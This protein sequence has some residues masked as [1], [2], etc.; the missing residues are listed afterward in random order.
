[1]TSIK[2]V[3]CRG[4]AL[5]GRREKT[6]GF[7]IIPLLLILAMLTAAAVLYTHVVLYELEAAGEFI[8]RSR[9]EAITQSFVQTALAEEGQT[10]IKDGSWRLGNLMP[11][12]VTADINVSVKRMKALGMR[13][14]FVSTT[15]T[16]GREFHLR[17]CRITLPKMLTDQFERSAFIVLKSLSQGAPSEQS[18][19]I[20]SE[21]AGAVFPQFYVDDFADWF[22][23]DFPE[24]QELQQDGFGNWIYVSH[25]L[26]EFP[27][28]LT[29]KGNGVLAFTRP[30]VI[31]DNVTFAGRVF[32]IANDDLRVGS[33]VNMQK[34][35]ILCRGNL[36]IG[37]DTAINGGFLVQHKA[38]LGDRVVLTRAE[39][40]IS[41]FN[42]AIVY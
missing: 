39:E 2:Q 4:R 6:G 23:R 27:Q 22:S 31:G 35:F 7:I 36:T 26:V 5:A 11:G 38:I 10:E 20:T 9:L 12:D 24:M 29:V 16:Q 3:A 33:N 41:A 8:A 14:L 42:T 34:A 18:M 17:Q 28:G 25:D 15:D 1:M 19:P 37:S 13:S 30:A 40:V 21:E 32:I